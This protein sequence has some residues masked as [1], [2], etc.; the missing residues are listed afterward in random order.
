MATLTMPKGL[1]NIDRAIASFALNAGKLNRQCHLIAMGIMHHAFTTGDCTRALALV[2]AMPASMRRTML[3]AWFAKYSPITVKL[4]DD[5]KVGLNKGKTANPFD[6]EGADAE[7][8]YELAEKIAEGKPFDL[9]TAIKM[10]EAL[11]KRIA[12]GLAE[13]DNLAEADRK[14]GQN[15]VRQLEAV[16]IAA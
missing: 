3:I 16:K 9:A 7:P 12:K 15:I 14:L 6:L 13:N 1:K 5:E 11:S 4:G 10:V 2:K 8:F